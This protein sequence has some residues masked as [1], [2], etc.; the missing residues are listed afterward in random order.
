M[1]ITDINITI[2]VSNNSDINMITRVNNKS[3][4]KHDYKSE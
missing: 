1:I 4:I 3:N 2:R